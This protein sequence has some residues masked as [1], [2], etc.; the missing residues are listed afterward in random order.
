M[1]DNSQLT[2]TDADIKRLRKEFASKKDLE[3]LEKRLEKKFVTKS[4][5]EILV[6][7]IHKMKDEFT[8]R[9]DQIMG[10]LKATREEQIVAFYQT[11]S[12]KETVNNHE[13]RIGLIEDKIAF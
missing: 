3:N 9:F 10:E 4:D 7:E 11:N 5:F 2:L 1:L 13:S 12:L 6:S 8:I